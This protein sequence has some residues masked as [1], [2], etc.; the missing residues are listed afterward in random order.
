MLWVDANVGGD[1]QSAIIL[2]VS[3]IAPRVTLRLI[4]HQE[5]TSHILMTILFYYQSCLQEVT[6]LEIALLEYY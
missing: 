6:F 3:G 2:S 1:F 5:M 4:A